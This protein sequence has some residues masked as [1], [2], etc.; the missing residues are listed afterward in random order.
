MITFHADVGTSALIA[1]GEI[2]LVSG[3]KLTELTETGAK[4]ADG[5]AVDADVVVY[6]TGFG[7]FKLALKKLFGDDV[8]AQTGPVWGINNEG[9]INGV[10]RGS[11]HRG[12]YVMM[13]A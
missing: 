7:D 3:T 6:A 10:W 1:S 4:F 2:K 5:R 13:G 9:E 8:A 12:L 11:G